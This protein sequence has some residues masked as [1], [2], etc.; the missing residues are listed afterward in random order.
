MV[1]YNAVARKIMEENRV[2]I[3]DLYKLALPRLVE[4]QDPSNVHYTPEGYEFLAK[5]VASNIA[6]LLSLS[7]ASK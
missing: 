5:H 6:F 3:N 4:I 1:L 2:Y 7:A